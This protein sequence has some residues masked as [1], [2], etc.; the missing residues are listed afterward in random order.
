MGMALPNRPALAGL[1]RI[2]SGKIRDLYAVGE[3]MAGESLLLV[4]SDYVSAFDWVL[5]T[6]I[7]NKGRILTQLSRWWFEQLPE[8]IPHHLIT[9]DVAEY[10]AELRPHADALRGRSMLCRRL[11]MA[12]V[13]CTAR[14]Y[15]A[16]SGLADYQATGAICGISLPPGLE[17]GS[18]FSEPLFT[19]ATKAP[20]GEHDENISYGQVVDMVGEKLAAELRQLT[21]M[22]YSWA[23]GVAGERGF[24]LAD[25]KFEFGR[26]AAGRLV[27]ADEVFTPDSSRFWRIADWQPGKPQ[28][29]FDKQYLRNWL[30]SPE[31]GWDRHSG[32][33]PPPLPDPVVQGIRATYLQAY[34]Q[35]TGQTFDG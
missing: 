25:T 34:Q 29:P 22:L 9:A 21:L 5:P 35:L 13:E 1:T 28:I 18:R 23:H 11:D 19:P 27:L 3:N 6:P 20:L 15:L 16:G 31:S 17:E 30:V 10:P 2:A 4:A 14:G 32:Q 8:D 12:P 7:P 24:V 33:P 26:D